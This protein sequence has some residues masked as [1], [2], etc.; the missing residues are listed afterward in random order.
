MIFLYGVIVYLLNFMKYV[1]FFL[2][3]GWNVVFYDYCCYGKF[4]G[5]I[6]SYGYYEKLD[7]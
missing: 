4:E 5:K 3:F 6:M 7:F 1:W 2:K